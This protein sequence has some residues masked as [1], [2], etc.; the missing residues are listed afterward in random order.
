MSGSKKRWIYYLCDLLLYAAAITAAAELF[1]NRAPKPPQAAEYFALSCF[2]LALI[3]NLPALLHEIGHLL[4]GI[5]AGMKLAGFHFRPFSRS[6]TEMFPMCGRHVRGKFL[7]FALGGAVFNLLIGGAFFALYFC[8]PY[9]PAL[10][11]LGLC[12]PFLVYEGLRALLPAE[13][14][15][16]K[17]DGMVLLGT[18]KK[19]PEEE[20]SL[21]V[22]EAQG[23]LYRESF[24]KIPRELLYDV[25]VVREDLPAFAALLFLRL[26]YELYTE[27]PAWEETLQRLN[28]L[29]EY[30]T[31]RQ[32]AELD[33]F[34]AL[35]EGKGE[36]G[37]KKEPLYG[38][39]ELKQRFNV[40]TK[41]AD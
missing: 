17:T 32:R 9:H 14:S 18:L 36:Q 35:L 7:A 26:Q 6:A 24:E 10:L 31:P 1:L 39:R 11:F 34:Q 13:L 5:F 3:F 28:S 22:L 23:I 40:K 38:V 2:L 27:D 21:R 37:A 12:A 33:E 15:A 4:F 19:S 30:F 20:I 41:N 16:G 25:P 29:E 8:L